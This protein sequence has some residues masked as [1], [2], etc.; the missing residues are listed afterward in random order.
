MFSLLEQH[1]DGTWWYHPRP[2]ST[3]D[4]PEEVEEA[5]KKIFWWDLSRLHMVFEHSKPL[6]QRYST[7][8]RDFKVFLFDDIIRWEIGGE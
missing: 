2:R 6:F 4:T 5:F 3:F 7:Y 8:T 1:I